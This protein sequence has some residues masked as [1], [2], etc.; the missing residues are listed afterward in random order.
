[1]WTD[2]RTALVCNCSADKFGAV[3]PSLL[4]SSSM[5]VALLYTQT[6]T[7]TDNHTCIDESETY[8]HKYTHRERQTDNTKSW[9][10]MQAYDN[11]N[12]NTQCS[13]Y[14]FYNFSKCWSIW[15]KIIS[16]C[17][18]RNFSNPLQCF[19]YW[20]TRAGARYKK[21]IRDVHKLR[22]I[23]LW[24]FFVK[25]LVCP[26]LEKLWQ[27]TKGSRFHGT[28]CRSWIKD[29]LKNWMFR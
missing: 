6:Y 11:A 5:Y 22:E 19:K 14:S 24:I 26:Y 7:Q 21:K 16:L 10:K 9:T 29:N 25:I 17:S 18:L 23:T 8:R 15:I 27:K 28:R 12:K 1:M 4:T 13:M 20:T 2:Q 3:T